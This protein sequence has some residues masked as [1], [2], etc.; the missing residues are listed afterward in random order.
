M[1]EP[2]GRT[3]MERMRAA[4][5]ASNAKALLDLYVEDAVM[6]I[7]DR[8]NPPSGS[9]RLTGKAEIGAYYEDVCGRVMTHRVT[10]TLVDGNRLAFAEECAYQ[11]GT[12]VY[13]SAIVEL[14]NGRIV[15]QTNVQAWDE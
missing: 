10:D 5:E 12:R 8:S 13:C 2:D 14:A 15:R 7:I 11:D 4:L 6:Q 3:I 1:S 9:R